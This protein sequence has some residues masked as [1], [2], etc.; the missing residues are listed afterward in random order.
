MN[1]DTIITIITILGVVLTQSYFQHQSTQDIIVSINARID[2]I[3]DRMT[4]FERIMIERGFSPMP[5]RD[6]KE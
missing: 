4:Y 2:K 6:E 5:R 3:D 1:K